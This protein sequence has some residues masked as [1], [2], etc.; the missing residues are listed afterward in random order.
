MRYDLFTQPV[1]ARLTGGQFDPN[2]ISST[3]RRGVI[4]VPGKGGFSD[5]IV[6][7][8][9]KNFAPRFGFAYQATPRF[10]IRGGY[11]IF[12]S[13]REQNDQTT[14]MALSLLNFRNITMP[15]PSRETT[16]APRYRFTSPLVVDSSI[17]PEFSRYNTANPLGADGGSN[18]AADIPYSPFPMLQQYNLS[19]QYEVLSGLLVEASYAGARGVHWVQRV[20]INTIRIEDVLA[21]KNRQA[22]RPFPFLAST[23]G[24]D[25]ANVSNR[26]NSFNLRIERRFAQGLTALANYTISRNVDTGNAGISTFS[27]QGNTRPMDSYNLKLEKAGLPRTSRKNSF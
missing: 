11:G 17:D 24:L 5:A 25:T 13:Q 26:Y 8:H 7:G 20:D 4:R 23:V 22:D 15:V 10:V 19:L 18:N 27:N 12:F 6:L 9:H 14:D 3:G 2:G 16:I 21:G 1:D